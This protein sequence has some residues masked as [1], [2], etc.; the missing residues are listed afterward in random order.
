MSR[1]KIVPARN[2]TIPVKIILKVVIYL[3]LKNLELVNFIIP[4]S[5]TTRRNKA[6]NAKAVKIPL[7]FSFI[8]YLVKTYEISLATDQEP[9]LKDGLVLKKINKNKLLCQGNPYRDF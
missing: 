3:A 7:F 6:K 4:R 5:R 9:F 2:I 8:I 1:N